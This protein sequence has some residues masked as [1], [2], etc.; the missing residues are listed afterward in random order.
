MVAYNFKPRFESPIRAGIKRQTIRAVG[1][2][3]HARPEDE[4]QLYVGMRTQRCKLMGRSICEQTSD[5]VIEFAADAMTVAVDGKR[6]TGKKLDT[7]AQADG[8]TDRHDMRQFWLT[9]H[10][11]GLVWHGVLVKWGDLL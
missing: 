6:L 10:K 4:V 2:R 5:I 1:R 11:P 7:F 9:E 3:R 8:F